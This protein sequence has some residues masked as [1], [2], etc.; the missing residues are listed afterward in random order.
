MPDTK[1]HYWREAGLAGQIDA[2][3]TRRARREAIVIVPLIVAVL[4]IYNYR[5]D[6]FGNDVAVRV[7]SVVVLVVLVGLFVAG[8][9]RR[10]EGGEVRRES[11]RRA[12]LEAAKEAKYREIRD[13]ELDFR[14]GK[15]SDE[16]FR[17]TDRELRAQAIGILEQLDEVGGG[18]PEP[19]PGPR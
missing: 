8:P 7:V 3:K 6:L 18:P 14:M 12:D 2:G 4:V 16:D 9:L 11:E 15:T 13:A 1:T 10:D 17:A 19:D 5:A